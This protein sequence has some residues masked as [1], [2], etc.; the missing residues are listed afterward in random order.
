[1]TAPTPTSTPYA[2]VVEQPWPD[3]QGALY[4]AAVVIDE[5]SYGPQ[6]SLGTFYETDRC[7]RAGSWP[8]DCGQAVGLGL[9]KTTDGRYWVQGRPVGLYAGNGGDCAPGDE[10]AQKASAIERLRLFEEPRLETIFASGATG[11]A[12]WLADPAAAVVLEGGLAVGWR[13]ALGSLEQEARAAYGGPVIIHAPAWMMPYYANLYLVRGGSPPVTHNGNLWSFGAYT[14][15]GPATPNASG[16]WIYATGQVTIR[17]GPVHTA[18]AFDPVLNRR[19]SL[20]ERTLVVST[21]CKVLAVQIDPDK[22]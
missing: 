14:G 9:S 15:A 8:V 12:P 19:I 22:I 6:W 13:K 3:R 10:D 17:R 20:A 16:F 4:A 5:G 1:M 18:A 21:E 11:I 7:S 2:E